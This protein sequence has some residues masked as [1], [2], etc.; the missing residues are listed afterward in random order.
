M[1][2]RIH[3]VFHVSLLK[4]QIGD[5][6]SIQKD[7]PVL[8]TN[9]EKVIPTSQ[10][11]LERR[12]RKKKHKVL[13]HWQGSSPADATWEDMAFMKEQFPNITLEDKGEI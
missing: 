6:V 10:A 4:K 12:I 2:S 9:N 13:I 5:N 8:S 1:G 7:L 3:P 11:V